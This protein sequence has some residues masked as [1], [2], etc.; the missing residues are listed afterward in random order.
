M[1]PASCRL[2][3]ATTRPYLVIPENQGPDASILV[4]CTACGLVIE[5]PRP[6]RETIDA[7]YANEAL[8][9]NSTDAEGNSRSYVKELEAKKAQFDDLVRR[10]ERYKTGGRL[11]DVGAGPGL[12]ERSLDAS[13]WTVLGVESSRFIAEYGPRT[14][15]SHVVHGYFED[16][17]IEPA[18]FDVI[19]MKYVLDHM[20]RPW[21]A[22]EH[23]R[24]LI[25]PDGLLV[26]ADLINIESFAARFF[27]EGHRLFH[28]MH[29]TYF[30]P[31][32]IRTHL[33]RAGFRIVRV[34]YPFVRTPYCTGKNL[35]T[36]AGRVVTR[37]LNRLRGNN[38]KVF[39]SAFYGNMMDV[40]AVPAAGSR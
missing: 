25:K 38:E 19:V 9:T 21:E 22:I 12:L 10:I 13:R 33:A 7:F 18:S 35:R 16:M 8:W 1:I 28:P 39:S 14:F 26:I 23:A 24:T 20:E 27:A 2:A 15:G 32:T 5:S 4:Q 29:F 11:L 30:S 17:A 37:A 34:E 6:S 40:F 3:C 31:A 36:F